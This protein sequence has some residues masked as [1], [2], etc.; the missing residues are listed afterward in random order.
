MAGEDAQ[1]LARWNARLMGTT[2]TPMTFFEL[3]T[4]AIE[5][6]G[7]S[8]ITVACT[9]RR[10][11]G[12]F[13]ANRIYLRVRYEDLFFDVSAFVAGSSL[14]VGYWLH[15]DHP[16]IQDLLSEVP[17]LGFAIERWIRPTT[18]Y[19]VDYI[20]SFQELIHGSILDVVDDLLVANGQDPVEI[21]ARAP[22]WEAVW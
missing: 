10:E 9:L 16:G 3:V 7:L 4:A 8:N 18:Y 6:R 1:I 22:I 15:R 13:S 11:G 19:I 21:E 14:I 2:C 20:S 17:I 12:I 5:N